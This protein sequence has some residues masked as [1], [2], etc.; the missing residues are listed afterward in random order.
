MSKIKTRNL[1]DERNN[2]KIVFFEIWGIFL[3]ILAIIIISELG[4]I[5]RLLSVF[6]LLMFGDWY[7]VFI[8]YQVYYGVYMITKHKFPKYNSLVIIGMIMIFSSL[9]VYSHF[10]IYRY[11]KTNNQSIVVGSWKLFMKYLNI[12]Y[13]NQIFGGGIVGALLFQLYHVLLGVVGTHIINAIVLANGIA[14]LFEKSLID[15]ITDVYKKLT[16]GYQSVKKFTKYS[17]G[18]MARN[19]NEKDDGKEIIVEDSHSEDFTE[20]VNNV[21]YENEIHVNLK[22][23]IKNFS[24]NRNQMYLKMQKEL[25]ITNG[26]LLNKILEENG[27]YLPIKEMTIGPTVTNYFLPK[28]MNIKYSKLLALNK[29]IQIVLKNNSIRY[30]SALKEKGYFIV[31]VPNKYRYNIFL[32]DIFN[33]FKAILELDNKVLLGLNSEGRKHY[34]PLN[35]NNIILISGIPGTGLTNIITVLLFNLIFFNND[36]YEVY[37]IDNKKVQY[38]QFHKVKI[39]KRIFYDTKDDLIEFLRLIDFIIDNR[40]RKFLANNVK[41]FEEYTSKFK[42][43]KKIVIFIDT[44]TSDVLNILRSKA[45]LFKR[46]GIHLVGIIDISM[47]QNEYKF[48][49]PISTTRIITKCNNDAFSEYFIG[50]K[51][52]KLLQPGGDVLLTNSNNT[53]WRIQIPFISKSDIK[54]VINT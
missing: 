31:Q 45:H 16:E 10:P 18:I 33:S 34:F 41:S 22:D 32:G 6:M 3:I 52:P 11:L 21:D 26:K 46:I 29:E 37:I 19:N 13:E 54:L 47:N 12:D 25:S 51:D 27:I 39:I 24:R 20:L 9:I 23:I 36:D 17:Y 38:Q 1:L 40:Q 14:F 44:F 30:Y 8:I 50:N 48:L 2:E 43:L 42:D 4:A 49:L 15:F 28:Q 35:G 5:G 53:M 7:W